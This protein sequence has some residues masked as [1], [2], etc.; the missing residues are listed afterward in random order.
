MERTDEQDPEIEE[1]GK[2]DKDEPGNE[3]VNKKYY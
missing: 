1:D 2:D 3:N